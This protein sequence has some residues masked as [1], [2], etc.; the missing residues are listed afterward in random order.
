[1]SSLTQPLNEI[2]GSVECIFLQIGTQGLFRKSYGY[3]RLEF[4]RV[5]ASIW[6]GHRHF[7]RGSVTNVLFPWLTIRYP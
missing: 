7:S 1:M 4:V 2:I 5:I 3:K 6:R